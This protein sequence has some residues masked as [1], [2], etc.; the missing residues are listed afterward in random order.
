MDLL[1][2]VR[3][4]RNRNQPIEI[5]VGWRGRRDVDES[6]MDGSERNAADDALRQG[7]FWTLSSTSTWFCTDLSTR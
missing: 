1:Q 6:K 2:L 5:W 4:E 3:S 7:W